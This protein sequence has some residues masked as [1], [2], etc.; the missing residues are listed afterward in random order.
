LSNA[1]TAV[2]LVPLGDGRWAGTWTPQ[3]PSPGNRVQITIRA[4]A[5]GIGLA[6]PMQRSGNLQ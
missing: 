3:N 2:N 5:Q 1:D 4:T 6:S